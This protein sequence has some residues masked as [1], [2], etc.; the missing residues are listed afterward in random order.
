M[1]F[2]GQGCAM[3]S[4]FYTKGNSVYTSFLSL[5]SSADVPNLV[6]SFAKITLILQSTFPDILCYLSS[7]PFGVHMKFFSHVK[8]QEKTS[9]SITICRPQPGANTA[10]GHCRGSRKTQS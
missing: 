7:T 10:Q 6:V 4:S 9:I 3:T 8:Q 5:L 1:C 2:G